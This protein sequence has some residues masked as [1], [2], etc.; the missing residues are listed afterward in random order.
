MSKSIVTRVLQFS[1][2]VDAKPLI[3]GTI[4]LLKMQEGFKTLKDIKRIGFVSKVIN[5]NNYE[6]TFKYIVGLYGQVKFITILADRNQILNLHLQDKVDINDNI[7][8]IISILDKYDY[9]TNSE[10]HDDFYQ[11]HLNMVSRV[12]NSSSGSSLLDNLTN[13]Y[14]NSSDIDITKLGKASGCRSRR[15]KSRHHKKTNRRRRK[16]NRRKMQDKK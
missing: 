15:R 16:S 11:N 2:A 6:V 14:S 9:L 13:R 12:N 1:D 4:V 5:S 10:S 8:K 7:E 3:K